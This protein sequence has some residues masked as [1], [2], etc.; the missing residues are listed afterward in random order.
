MT[1]LRLRSGYLLQVAIK[2]GVVVDE[3]RSWGMV[4][5]LRCSNRIAAVIDGPVQRLAIMIDVHCLFHVTIN[6]AFF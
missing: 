4:C 2:R 6:V 5:A 3:Q 1:V